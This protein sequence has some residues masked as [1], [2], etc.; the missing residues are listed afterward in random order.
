MQA[1]EES[2]TWSYYNIGILY[3]TIKGFQILPFTERF[4]VSP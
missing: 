2:T 4:V 3:E 1:A